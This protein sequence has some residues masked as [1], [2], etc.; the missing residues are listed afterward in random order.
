MSAPARSLI[1]AGFLLSLAACRASS[2][3][4]GPSIQDSDSGSTDTDDTGDLVDDT[5][6]V[7]PTW[8]PRF[9]PLVSQLEAELADNLAQGVSVAIWYQGELV[10]VEAFGTARPDAEGE[11]DLPLTPSSLLQVGSTT[12]MHTSV[13]LLQQIDAGRLAL[14]DTLDVAL[15]ELDF[16]NNPGVTEQIE[17]NHLLSHQGA[18]YDWIPWDMSPE[19]SQLQSYTYD[20][21]DDNL[22]VMATPGSFF[23]YSNPN[24]VLAGVLTED[25]DPEG[26]TWPDY[27]VEEVY[28]PLG[29][30]RTYA[31]R[32]DVSDDG[33]Y[34][35]GYGYVDIET[36]ELGAGRISQ[37]T[38]PGWARPAGMTW[39]TPT[40]MIQF[41]RFLMKDPEVNGDGAVLSEE[42]VDRMHAGEVLLGTTGDD[43]AYGH[44][45]FV[46]PGVRMGE[47]EYLETPVWQHGGN[48]LFFTSEFYVLPEHDFALS[49]L[50]NGYGDGWSGSIVQAVQ[51]TVEDLPEPMEP[52]SLGLDLDGL[53]AHVGH[54]DDP[55]NVGEMILTREGDTLLVDMPFLD[56]LGFEV[57]DE[58]YTASTDIHYVQIDGNWMDLRFLREAPEDELSTWAA[59]R[60]FVVTRSDE[61]ETSGPPAPL[62]VHE[63]AERARRIRQ[64]LMQAQ[65]SALELPPG[66]R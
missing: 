44:G 43:A 54:Y 16:L 33:D 9:D 48:T 14:D 31:R 32:S 52:P 38:D 25:L 45:L 26:R 46:H 36:G 42:L 65:P 10:F 22:W 66:L 60:A 27:I 34:S 30:D 1:Y 55:F 17:V 5:G 63:R 20:V 11:D 23:N 15:P 64:S 12:K 56:E 3:D 13:G 35:L 21:F 2:D 19:D 51:L 4:T 47:D 61:A 59:N 39:S 49:I 29:M 41:A 57:G 53:D 62:S 8:D 50:S 40:Q 28:Q 6:E 7:S 58:L 37:I 18:F 24:F